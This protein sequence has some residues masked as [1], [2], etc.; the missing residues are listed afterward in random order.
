MVVVELLWHVLPVLWW[1]K[2]PR[3]IGLSLSSTCCSSSA[4]PSRCRACLFLFT[5]ASAIITNADILWWSLSE[6]YCLVREETVT[7]NLSWNLVKGTWP[8]LKEVTAKL[9][10]ISTRVA[11]QNSSDNA[12]RPWYWMTRSDSES[13]QVRNALL[14]QGESVAQRPFWEEEQCLD[15]WW[16]SGVGMAR[17]WQVPSWTCTSHSK[18]RR[19]LLLGDCPK[20]S[21]EG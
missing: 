14:V 17:N 19:W 1:L 16:M 10:A 7:S 20:E 21:D 5:S 18:W 4:T 9:S 13:L 6:R 8:E 12:A 3:A 2:P 11:E 15:G